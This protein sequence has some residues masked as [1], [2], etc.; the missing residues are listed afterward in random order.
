[1]SKFLQ[2]CLY[3]KNALENQLVNVVY[4]CHDLMCGCLSPIE[5]LNE[6]INKQKCHLTKDIGIQT[7]ESDTG[8]QK[9]IDTFDAGDLE[10]LFKE[11][12]E[13]TG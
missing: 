1:M 11:N 13:S 10:E 9:E 8:N 4:G 7:G 5:H 12:A 3:E 2:P 6:I